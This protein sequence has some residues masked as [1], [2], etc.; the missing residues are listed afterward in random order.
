MTSSGSR[1]LCRAPTRL[2]RGA[3]PGLGSW[4]SPPGG[5]SWLGEHTQVDAGFAH[6]LDDVELAHHHRHEV[7]GHHRARLKLHNLPVWGRA[8]RRGA[9]RGNR[10]NQTPTF[11]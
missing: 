3:V 4:G 1:S 9:L 5:L 6:V 10:K 11:K 7:G 2:L 8:R